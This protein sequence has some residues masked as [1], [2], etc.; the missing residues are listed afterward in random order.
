[1]VAVSRRQR[2][3]GKSGGDS[4]SCAASAH[5]Y[6]GLAKRVGDLC[7]HAETPFDVFTTMKTKAATDA[8]DMVNMNS[9]F[10][11]AYD[12]S[13]AVDL[14]KKNPSGPARGKK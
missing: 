6:P 7:G 9:G 8:K 4:G 10:I 5:G 14:I 11:I 12:I 1:M 3:P 2:R 13:H